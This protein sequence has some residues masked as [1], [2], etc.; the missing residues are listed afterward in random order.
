MYTVNSKIVT[1]EQKRKILIHIAA[2]RFIV[3][4]EQDDVNN[5]FV[6]G[7]RF[8]NDEQVFQAFCMANIKSGQLELNDDTL[9]DLAE[10]A[11]ISAGECDYYYMYEKEY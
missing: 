10:K 1:A 6:S 5:E 9:P 8:N 3:K 7:S 11:L 4:I 2:L